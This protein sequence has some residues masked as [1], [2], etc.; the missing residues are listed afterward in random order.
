MKFSNSNSLNGLTIGGEMKVNWTSTDDFTTTDP[1][2][3]KL[4]F[5]R[6][7]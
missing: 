3:T 7:K 5:I 2:G 4:L 1:Q 6:S